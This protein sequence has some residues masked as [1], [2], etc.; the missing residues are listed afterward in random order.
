MGHDVGHGIGLAIGHGVGHGLG[1]GIGHGLGHGSG[2]HDGHYYGHYGLY[3]G[4]GYYSPYYYPSYYY[5]YYGSYAGYGYPSYYYDSYAYAPVYVES[6]DASDRYT[7]EVPDAQAVPEPGGEGPDV[8][9]QSGDD[10]PSVPD[11]VVVPRPLVEPQVAPE[12]L[13]PEDEQELPNGLEEEEDAPHSRANGL[14]AGEK[15]R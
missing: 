15:Q 8:A 5:P 3:A 9:G 14:Q 4:H 1:H 13:P 7:D 10:E 2:P 12:V 6:D 11:G